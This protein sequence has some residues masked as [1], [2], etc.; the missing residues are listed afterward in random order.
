MA[1]EA[2][3]RLDQTLAGLRK[4]QAWPLRERQAPISHTTNFDFAAHTSLCTL[5]S[6]N[7]QRQPA[8]SIP[9]PHSITHATFNMAISPQ[10][11]VTGTRKI[12]QQLLT[13]RSTNLVLIL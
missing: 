4:V 10:M 5:T 6:L 1:L 8:A 12:A 2:R 11:Y 13:A 9:K 3:P 7:R